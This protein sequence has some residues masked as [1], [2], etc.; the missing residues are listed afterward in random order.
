MKERTEILLSV[1]RYD[2]NW[3]H[4]YALKKPLHVPAGTRIECVGVFDNSAANPNN[5]DPAKEVRWG[6]QSWEEMMLGSV[7]YVHANEPYKKDQR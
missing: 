1:P 3:Q 5:P 7:I 4:T 2:F 6:E